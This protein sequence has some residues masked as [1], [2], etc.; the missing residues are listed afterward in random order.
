MKAPIL[1]KIAGSYPAVFSLIREVLF[2]R[3]CALCETMLANAEDAFFGICTACRNA[4]D[5]PPAAR[6]RCSLCGKPLISESVTCLPCRNERAF[7][8]EPESGVANHSLHGSPLAHSFDRVIP[9]YPYMGKYRK[10]LAAY[11]FGQYLNVGNFFANKLLQGFEILQNE[12][13]FADGGTVKPFWVPVPPKPGKIKKTGWDQIEY[14]ARRLE[15]TQIPVTRCL[16]R[17]SSESQKQLNREE[18][19]ENLKNKIL[20]KDGKNLLIPETAIL[21]DDVY[22]TGATMDACAAALKSGGAK[23]VYGICLFYD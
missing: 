9:L 5:V 11:K 10:V 6:G 16:K 1:S 19:L 22:T 7:P 12:P 4:L 8:T 20:I 17:L 2:P 21:F 23:K 14:L 13:S 15:K 18:R 3:G